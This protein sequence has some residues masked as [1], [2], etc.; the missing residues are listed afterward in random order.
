M[1][2]K[3]D[4]VGELHHGR[5]VVG[6]RGLVGVVKDAGR[7]IHLQ[8]IQAGTSALML[9]LERPA[10]DGGTPACTDGPVKPQVWHHPQAQAR[11]EFETHATVC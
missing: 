4:A 2:A 11:A 8:G 1:E 3:R 10:D 7:I 9:V 6:M 5:V